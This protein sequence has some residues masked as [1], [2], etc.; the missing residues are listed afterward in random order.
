MEKGLIG[1]VRFIKHYKFMNLVSVE[2]ITCVETCV[3]KKRCAAEA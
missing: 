1:L 2:V 3:W